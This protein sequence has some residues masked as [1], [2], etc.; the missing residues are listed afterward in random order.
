MGMKVLVTGSSGFVGRR[1]VLRLLDE[2]HKVIAYDL[3]PLILQNYSSRSICIIT[4]DLSLGEGFNRIVW[5]ELDVIIHLAAAGVKASRRVWSECVSVN[6]LGTA[7]LL[8]SIGSISTFPLVV[9]PQTFYERFLGD[10]HEFTNNPY[11]VTK[12]AATQIVKLWADINVNASIV[13]GTFFQVYGPNDDAGNVLN[14]IAECL[15]RGVTAELGSGR[16]LRDWIYI[17]DLVDAIIKASSTSAKGIQYFDFGTGELTSLM[18]VAQTLT[19]LLGRPSDLLDF[20]PRRDRGDLTLNCCARNLLP[21]WKP[22]YSLERGLT[23]LVHEIS[24]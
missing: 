8:K 23:S 7:Q 19:R 2:G 1:V 10:I 16:G 3:K 22:E 18:S 4:G 24:T 20:D 12:D 5:E 14:Y 13:I 21:G 15:R 6:I 11:I 9:Y 17:D